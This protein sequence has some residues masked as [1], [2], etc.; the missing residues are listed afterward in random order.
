MRRRGLP[1]YQAHT[2]MFAILIVATIALIANTVKVVSPSPYLYAGSNAAAYQGPHPTFAFTYVIVV[3]TAMAVMALASLALGIDVAGLRAR[4]ATR[5]SA[6]VGLAWS[7]LLFAGVSAPAALPCSRGVVPDP[8]VWPTFKPVGDPVYFYMGKVTSDLQLHTPTYVAAQGMYVNLCS[9]ATQ[10]A[11]HWATGLVTLAIA[12]TVLPAI[13]G[14][15]IV[16]IG[17]TTALRPATV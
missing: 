3:F 16:R 12:L 2:G 15:V 4:V 1:I 17:R 10:A 6:I 13:A 9:T 7:W 5:A 14:F 8:F 11:A